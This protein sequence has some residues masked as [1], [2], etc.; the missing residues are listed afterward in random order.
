VPA[1]RGR[2]A[3]PEHLTARLAGLSTVEQERALAELV[4]AQV[5]AVLGHDSPESVDAGQAFK[6]LGFDS[7]TAVDLRN[8]LAAATGLRLPATLVFDYPTPASLAPYLRDRVCPAPA[9]AATPVLADLD[10]VEA[11]LVGLPAGNGARDKVA[12]RLKGLLWRLSDT[13][14]GT[15]PAGSDIE[16]ASVEEILDLIDNDL[17]IS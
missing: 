6:D 1:G 3:G 7:L 8:R 2:D 5:A 10:R 4:R 9:D 13:P 11:A 16:T 17:G 12:A 15:A 14:A